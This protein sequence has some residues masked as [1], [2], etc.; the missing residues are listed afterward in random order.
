MIIVII[1]MIVMIPPVPPAGI[2]Q[3]A[4]RLGRYQESPGF[5]WDGGAGKLPTPNIHDKR[6]GS[7]PEESKNQGHSATPLVGYVGDYSPT[8]TFKRVNL[9]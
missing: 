6:P 9:T 4:A 1:V 7:Q 8:T 3:L 5:K 2:R